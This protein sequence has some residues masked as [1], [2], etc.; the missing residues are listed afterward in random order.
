MLQAFVITFR[1]A[2][3]ALMIV[4]ISLS[5]LRKTGRAHLRAP[6]WW[7][8]PVSLLTSAI[9]GYLFSLASNQAL[10]EGTLAI[11]AAFS[12]ATLVVH[13]WRA[14]SRIKNNI[15]ERLN[16]AAQ[17]GSR[18][19]AW[20]GIFLFT[21]FMITREGMEAAL[22]LGT[23]VFQI[24]AAPMIMGAVAGIVAAAAIALLW[25]RFGL[26]I[27]LPRFL[28]VTAVFI[29]MFVIQLLIYGIH[30]LSEAAV[31]PNSA[32]IHDATEPYGPQGIYGSWL[33]FALVAIPL[34]WL[35]LS[36]VNDR[37]RRRKSLPTTQSLAPSTN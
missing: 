29:F 22:M 16:E 23:L 35:L 17:A 4:A 20:L 30:E 8:I 14:A 13:T 12:V 31:L 5:Y 21:V 7:A 28:Q 11:V 25:S 10:W 37:S 24:K 36:F 33:S 27:N 26:R 3:E 19:M 18:R 2:I 9:A 6:V 32:Q 1:E 15:Q 34:A